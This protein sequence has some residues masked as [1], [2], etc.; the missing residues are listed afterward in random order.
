MPCHL[1]P[2]AKV[3]EVAALTS[4]LSTTGH[5]GVTT[6]AAACRQRDVTYIAWFGRATDGGA[7]REYGLLSIHT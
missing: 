3:T 2:R 1:Q 5:R 6:G 7:A 4:L